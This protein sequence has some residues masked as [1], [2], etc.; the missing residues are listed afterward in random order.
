MNKFEKRPILIVEDSD[1]DYDATIWALGD[2]AKSIPLVR[3]SGGEEVMKYLENR[4]SFAL[5]AERP[6]PALILL[7]LNLPRMNGLEILRYI[8]NSPYARLLPVVILTTSANPAD[9]EASY[10]GGANTFFLKP[11]DLLEFRKTLDV[12]VTYWA[13]HAILPMSRT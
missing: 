1:S 7:D 8:R 13:L 10:R 2:H 11:F 9:V 3:C 4:G 6:A 12:V 5:D